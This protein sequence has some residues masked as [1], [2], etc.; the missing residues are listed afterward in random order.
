MFVNAIFSEGF[1]IT[2]VGRCVGREGRGERRRG[3]KVV[4]KG[5]E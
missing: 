1:D 2:G 5:G 4:R 3:R